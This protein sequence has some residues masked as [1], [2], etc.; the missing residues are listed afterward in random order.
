M[1][2][3]L[4]CSDVG[5]CCSDYALA[6]VLDVTRRI[7]ELIQI[8]VP[9]I[10]IV[11]A[12]I[13]LAQLVMN[14]DEK[15]GIKKITNKFIAAAVV[16][17]IPVLFNM[18]LGI[19]P[20]DY[21]IRSCWDQAKVMREISRETKQQYAPFDD[22]RKVSKI[23]IE[24]QYEKGDPVTNNGNG[25]GTGSGTQTG[26][27]MN[28]VETKGVLSWPAPTCTRISSTF[29]PRSAPVAGAS[30][31]HRGIDI[32]CTSGSDVTAAY[33]G[34]VT[35]VKDG[36]NSDGYNGGRGYFVVVK[37]TING[38]LMHTV[39]QHLSKPLVSVGTTVKKGQVIAKSGG[40]PGSPGAGATSGAHLHFEVHNGEFA[41]HVNEVNP[42]NYLG[43]SKCIGDISSDL[44]R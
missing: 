6:N 21:S 33:D 27:G 16:F 15:D 28:L 5:S 40:N 17:L 13:Q 37:H 44:K 23:I 34:T 20:E 31:N 42:C 35:I 22:S 9:I 43:L 3:I 2:Q 4:D 12:T 38:N 30:T 29:G 8:I 1:F 36:S 26:G 10:L 18:S 25:N 41:W 32:A 24:G 11:F 14:P 7:V 19:L 39:Y